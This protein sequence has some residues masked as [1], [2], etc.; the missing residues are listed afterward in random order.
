MGS[1]FETLGSPDPFEFSF[2]SW[3]LSWCSRDV[4]KWGTNKIIVILKDEAKGIIFLLFQAR[5]RPLRQMGHEQD[6]H[7]SNIPQAALRTS[8]S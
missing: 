7:T 1:V 3:L 6:H 8:Q 2:C 5:H 4:S